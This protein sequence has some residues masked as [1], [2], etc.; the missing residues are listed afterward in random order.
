VKFKNN[1]N[2]IDRN[3]HAIYQ[4]LTGTFFPKARIIGAR[5][6]YRMRTA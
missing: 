4:A 2:N 6:R 5:C 3:V 1:T